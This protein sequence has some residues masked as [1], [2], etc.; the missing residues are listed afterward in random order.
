VS[1]VIIS[2]IFSCD[3]YAMKNTN[4]YPTERKHTAIRDAG[5][6]QWLTRYDEEYDLEDD[7]VYDIDEGRFVKRKK[8]GDDTV[9]VE[10]EDY[11][12]RKK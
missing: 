9:E 11:P 8:A 6:M 7:Y 12:Q 1:R 3:L 2:G 4:T 5:K 10:V